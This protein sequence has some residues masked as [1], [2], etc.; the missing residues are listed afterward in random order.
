MRKKAFTL[1]ELLVVISIIALLV[2]ILMPALGKAREQARR[3][4]CLSNLKQQGIGLLMYSHDNNDAMPLT[5]YYG[6]NRWL[7]DVSYFTTDVMISSGGDKKIFHC[8]SNKIDTL[9]TEYWRYTEVSTQG[10]GA[11]AVNAVDATAEPTGDNL[12]QWHFRVVS[13]FYM[14]DFLDT[15]T[16]NVY[17]RGQTPG[18]PGVQWI[19]KTNVKNPAS[20]PL[21]TDCTAKYP[22]GQWNL[23]NRVGQWSMGTNH[24]D[25]SEPAGSNTIYVDNHAAWRPFQGET[26]HPN[27]QHTAGC[28]YDD[29]IMHRYTQDGVKFWW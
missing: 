27:H 2:A 21:I 12:R 10:G 3:T 13:Y 1:I 26:A 15:P 6:G 28:T 17:G 24:M 22:N 19:T 29:V 7:W 4:L 18:L 14:M 5:A 8:P 11:A 9:R 20:S 25:T 23:P 16:G